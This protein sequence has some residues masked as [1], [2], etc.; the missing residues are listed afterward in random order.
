VGITVKG[1]GKQGLLVE[2]VLLLLLFTGVRR[3]EL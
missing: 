3:F 1:G 2:L